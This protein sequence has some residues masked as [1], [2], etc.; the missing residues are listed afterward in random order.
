MFCFLSIKNEEMMDKVLTLFFDE[1]FNAGITLFIDNLFGM[2]LMSYHP[3]ISILNNQIYRINKQK[4]R[5]YKLIT[6]FAY[7]S[8]MIFFI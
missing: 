3:Q 2:I 1:F 7:D 8:S 5:N 4:N 6:R